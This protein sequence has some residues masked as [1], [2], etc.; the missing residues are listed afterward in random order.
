[1]AEY[2][3]FILE[4]ASGCTLVDIDGNEYLDGVSSLWCNVHGHRHPTI[5]TAVK[6]Q[7]DRV[8]HVT[9]LGVSNPQAIELARRLVEVTPEGLQHVFFSD[10][11]ATSVE[12]ALKIAFQYWQQCENPH[13]EKTRYIALGEAYHGDTLGVVSVGGVTRFHNIFHP[14]LFEVLRQPTPDTYRLPEGVSPEAA[15]EYYLDQVESLL[16]EHHNEVAALVMEPLVQGAAGIVVHPEGFLSGVRELTRKYEVLLIVDEVATGFGRT[17]KMFAC[18]HEDVQPDLMCMAKGIT[19]GYLPVAATLATDEVYRAFLGRY[20][21]FKTFF[22][23]HTYG[24]NPLG[25]AAALASLRLFQEEKTLENL[26][27]KI[28]RLSEHLRRIYS[29]EHVGD[30]RQRGMIGGIELVADRATKTPFPFGEKRGYRACDHAR[31]LGVWLRPLGD[32]LVIMPPLSVTL[33]QLDQICLAAE[34]GIRRAT[35]G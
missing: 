17:G 10:S 11:G 12:A 21:E 30:V 34:E 13:P 33:D 16:G 26:G 2:E 1:M 31:S 20:D 25:C 29:L 19:G 23:G 8:A 3:P 22:H 35:E 18:E 6:E 28:E 4:R 7:L 27:P 9:N 32:V 5:D 15:C 24:G 14:L